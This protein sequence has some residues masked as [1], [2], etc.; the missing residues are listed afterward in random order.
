[1]PLLYWSSDVNKV[2]EYIFWKSYA[3]TKGSYKADI[4]FRDGFYE[5]DAKWFNSNILGMLAMAKCAPTE[6]L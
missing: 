5:T 6:T 3:F 2:L 4:L 1:M